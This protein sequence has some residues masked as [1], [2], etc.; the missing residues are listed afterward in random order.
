MEVSI[1]VP[2]RIGAKLKSRGKDL[3]RRTLEALATS[4]YRE[5]LLTAA[6]VQEMLDLSSRWETDELLKQSGA[7]MGYSEKDLRKDA[8]TLERLLGG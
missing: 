7:W 5:G 6:E 3:P 2:D 4:G 8:E 1:R